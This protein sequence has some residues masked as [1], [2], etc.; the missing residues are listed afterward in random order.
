MILGAFIDAGADV[1]L[2]K[3]LPAKMNLPQVEI[4]INKVVKNG[5]SATKVDVL[6][7]HEHVH[8]HL[9]DIIDIIENSDIPE[10]AKLRAIKIFTRLAKSEARV[11]N[12]NIE[13]IHFHEVGAL[14][15]IIDITGSSLLF[16]S[17]NIDKVYTSAISVGG[18]MV[19]MAHGLY[20][21]PAPATT[22]L[23]ENF[24]IKFGPV[25]KE[26]ATP[27]G[28]A[29]VSTL[30]TEKTP[31]PSFAIDSIGYGAGTSNF[32]N[33]PN[34]LRVTIGKIETTQTHD[35]ALMLEC[36]IDDMSPEIIPYLIEQV[37]EAGAV[38]AFVTPIIMK[39]GRPAYLFNVLTHPEKEDDVFSVIFKETTTIGVRKQKFERT[40]LNRTFRKMK[41]AFGELSIK[42]ISMFDGS[43]RRTAEY[44]DLKKIAKESG[45]PLKEIQREIEFKLNNLEDDSK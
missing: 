42:E 10:S 25:E 22:Y 5:L 26:L 19:K 43:I 17:L 14:D 6:Y 23:L 39:K 32:E 40:I 38:D 21:V 2:L 45:K 3:N 18:G 44:E 12:T 4:K 27:T 16:D 30:V 35:H 34:A 28:A 36:N 8:R 20:P 24:D 13:K 37:M 11:H 33:V 31:L 15:A 1:K 7:P 9:S 41:T 29:I